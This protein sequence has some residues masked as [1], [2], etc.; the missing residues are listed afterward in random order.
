MSGA[1]AGASTGMMLGGPA[2]AGVGAVIGGLGGAIWANYE[3]SLDRFKDSL[4]NATHALDGIGKRMG[5]TSSL[6]EL[7]NS[8]QSA[9]D[10][11]RLLAMSSR[12]VDALGNV[13]IAPE[14]TMSGRIQQY[15]RVGAK[16][17]LG[18]SPITDLALAMKDIG[19]SNADDVTLQAIA[20]VQKSYGPQQA[21]AYVKTM[22]AVDPQAGESIGRAR[23]AARKALPIARAGFQIAD[24]TPVDETVAAAQLVQAK[25]LLPTEDPTKLQ[26]LVYS[27]F[28]TP[29]MKPGIIKTMIE[30]LA[31]R[32]AQWMADPDAAKFAGKYGFNTKKRGGWSSGL[33]VADM[34]DTFTANLAEKYKAAP[35]EASREA[36]TGQFFTDY[37]AAKLP[38]SAPLTRGIVAIAQRRAQG[39]TPLGYVAENAPSRVPLLSQTAPEYDIGYAS[40]LGTTDAILNDLLGI[41]NVAGQIER[42]DDPTKA[43]RQTLAEMTSGLASESRTVVGEQYQAQEDQR[44]SAERTLQEQLARNTA[45]LAE[46]TKT[47]DLFAQSV[48][49]A[50]QMLNGAI[51][52]V[53]RDQLPRITATDVGRGAIK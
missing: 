50:M 10:K 48:E 13:T 16:V 23:E 31:S 21:L 19:I 9:L 51:D 18:L 47:H 22:L 15:Q 52:V 11:T 49:R 17:G 25:A 5:A 39:L 20:Q 3:M 35:D 44:L 14:N 40:S 36:I 4:S 33:T 41:P 12:N 38:R 29:G 32:G 1:L 30:H 34:F 24:L 8:T 2:G 37:M 6:D 27:A 45:T 26:N 43:R 53:T 28:A 7:M 42:T 46:Y